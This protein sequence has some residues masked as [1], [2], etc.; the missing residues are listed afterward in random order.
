ML[1]TASFQLGP[2]GPRAQNPSIVFKVT[3]RELELVPILL[4]LMAE[5]NVLALRRKIKIV[6]QKQ[7]DVLVRN[8]SSVSRSFFFSGI[9]TYR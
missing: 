1:W 5:T 4:Q 6:P 7:M 9:I 8:S 2:P 3:R